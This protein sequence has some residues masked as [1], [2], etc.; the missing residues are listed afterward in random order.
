MDVRHDVLAEPRV[1]DDVRNLV[2]HLVADGAPTTQ[3]RRYLGILIFLLYVDIPEYNPPSFLA[4]PAPMY[5]HLVDVDVGSTVRSILRRALEVTMG[6][7]VA[8]PVIAA[9]RGDLGRQVDKVFIA[10]D[11]IPEA[12]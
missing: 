10:L 8:R 7:N 11:I 9:E 2:F 1:R 6:T 12:P 3:Q 4:F 5:L